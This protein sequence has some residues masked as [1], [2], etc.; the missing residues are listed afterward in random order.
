[1]P[2]DGTLTASSPRWFRHA[3]LAAYGSVYTTHTC[4]ECD[5]RHTRIA[6]L[7]EPPLQCT[8]GTL[9]HRRRHPPEG[10]KG[11]GE[12]APRQRCMWPS[13]KRAISSNASRVSGASGFKVHC[14]CDSASKT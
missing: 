11:R 7:K 10:P 12:E 4:E 5:I 2:A 14:T 3:P 13:K 6:W 1:M 8:L 9:W